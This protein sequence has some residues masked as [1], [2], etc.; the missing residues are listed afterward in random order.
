MGQ[1][2]HILSTIDLSRKTATCGACGPTQIYVYPNG[3]LKCRTAKKEHN[4]KYNAS[5]N[6]KAKKA[7]YTRKWKY[8][9]T[10]ETLTAHMKD[11]CEVCASTERLCLDHDHTTGA[12]RGTLCHG[13]NV[14]LGFLKENPTRIRALAEYA[15]RFG[16]PG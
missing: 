13:C 12:L 5:A 2:R 15:E 7:Q 9:A 11:A 4:V 3:K 14:S 6:R 1:H 10:V 16:R 8:A